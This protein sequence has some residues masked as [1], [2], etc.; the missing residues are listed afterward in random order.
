MSEVKSGSSFKK[1]ILFITLIVV[2]ISAGVFSFYYFGAYERGAMS[3]KVMRIAEKG[4]VFKTY[5]GKI[6]LETFGALKGAHPIQ[7]V[8]DFSVEK[9]K[10]DVIKELQEVAL[11]GERVNLYYVKRYAK[12]V[13]RGESQY[14][15]ERVERLGD[16]Q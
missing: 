3:G 6:N 9:S 12:F 4:V 11:S 5:E 2:L 14:F 13:W 7:E 15:V 10:T 1:I 16:P 8:F